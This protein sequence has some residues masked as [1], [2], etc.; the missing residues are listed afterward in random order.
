VGLVDELC[1]AAPTVVVL[2]DV[3][4]A[5]DASL[6]VWHQLAA[7]IGQLRLLL[8]GTCRPTPRRPEVQELRAAVIR[9]GGAVVALGPLPD[10][11]VTTLVTAML[12]SPPG[13]ALRQLTAQAAGNPLYVRELVDAMVREQALEVGRAATEVSAAGEQLPASLTA[14]LTDRLSSV[15]AGTAQMLR[16]A[17]L[18]GGRFAVTDLAVVL[19]RPASELAAD[20]QEAVAAGIL[21]E[22]PNDPDLAFRHLLIQQAL[23][24]SMPAALRTALHA[25]AARELAATGADALSVAQQLSAAKRPGEAWVRK[26]L[27]ESGPALAARAPPAK[28]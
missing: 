27:I 14:V 2:D 19:R 25:E 7:S 3:Q 20:V 4:W 16:T 8:I 26:W 13:D 12:G 23:Y 9:R 18:L 11:D 1:A 15:S 6:V 21:T 17:A 10:T 24:E 22:H 28:R 5:D